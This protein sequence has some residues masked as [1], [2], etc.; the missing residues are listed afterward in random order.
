MR[1]CWLLIPLA[2]ADPLPCLRHSPAEIRPAVHSMQECRRAQIGPGAQS[3]QR[4][5]AAEV[6]TVWQCA[7]R[8]VS[9]INAYACRHRITSNFQSSR[10][11]GSGCLM[12]SIGSPL[13]SRLGV[14]ISRMVGTAYRNRIAGDARNGHSSN[15]EQVGQFPS[16]SRRDCRHEQI[17][18]IGC[19]ESSA[20][21]KDEKRYWCHGLWHPATRLPSHGPGSCHAQIRAVVMK[22]R[23]R[24]P[25]SANVAGCVVE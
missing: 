16:E 5:H 2:P 10:D 13:C 11:R 14:P 4:G 12:P 15:G 21:A 17:Y 6:H 20:G 22:A 3:W 7:V 25:S 24:V 19:A 18:T 23:I 9:R 8:L 1:R